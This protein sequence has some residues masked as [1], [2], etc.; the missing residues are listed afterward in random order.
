M[1]RQQT[2]VVVEDGAG[3]AQRGRQRA[4]DPADLH[5]E[6]FIR[7]GRGVAQDIDGDGGAAFAS[8]D[9]QGGGGQGDVVAAGGGGAI[10]SGGGE[11]HPARTGRLAQAQREHEAAGA[12][13]AFGTA[14]IGQRGDRLAAAT[15]QARG[16]GGIAW[17]RRAGG[18]IGRVVVGIGA[19]VVAA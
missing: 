15:A 12:A 10:D 16:A 14:D 2:E 13:V 6:A 19:T 3:S 8:G 11:A 18:E 1:D 7:L 4:G 5:A 17:G 9:A